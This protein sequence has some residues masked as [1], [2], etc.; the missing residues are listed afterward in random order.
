MK[1]TTTKAVVDLPADTEPLLHQVAGHFYGNAKTRFGLLQRCSTGD[2][3][4]PLNDKV[5]GPSEWRFY[6]NVFA[7]G[8]SANLRALRPFLPTLLGTDDYEG[9]S[10]LVLE[11]IVRKFVHPCVADVKIGRIT[12][13]FLA[14]EEDI[15]KT[16][17]RYPPLAEVGFQLVGWQNYRPFENRYEYHDKICGRSLKKEEVIHG[18]A[19]FYGAPTS[20]YRR[21]VRCVLERLT[22]LEDAMAKQHGLIFVSSSLLIVYEGDNAHSIHSIQES[23]VDVRLIDLCKVFRVEQYADSTGL[24]DNFLDGLRSY[25]NCLRRLLDDTYVYSSVGKLR[26]ANC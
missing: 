1:E 21:V 25:K 3:L 16:Y 11:N 7:D 10:Y 20:D 23:K 15:E 24:E 26:G 12:Y 17:R 18:I 9:T 2:V 22:A 4:K 5:R 14:S 6:Q 13:D 8:A 19:N